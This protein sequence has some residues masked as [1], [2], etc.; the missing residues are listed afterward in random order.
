MIAWDLARGAGLAALVFLS[1]ST[2]LGALMTGRGRAAKRVVAQY[3][4]RATAA[5]G[6]GALLLHLGAI[7]AD[8]F[9]H[10]GW[11]GAIVPLQSGYRPLW[12]GLG[13]VAV[14]TFVGVAALGLAR[15]R[16]AASAVGARLWRGLHG[17]AYV[18]W[19]AAILHGLKAGTDTTVP[20]V[21]L[22]Y[23]ACAALVTGAIGARVS[24]ESRRLLI[25]A[26]AR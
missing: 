9:A 16:M 21:R 14:Y 6:L 5:L 24:M 25:P 15:G 1:I 8:R 2:A 22:L 18:G 3:V 4:H 19:F 13:T 17:L 12:V 20:W 11:I 7:L 23:I 26:V 10:V